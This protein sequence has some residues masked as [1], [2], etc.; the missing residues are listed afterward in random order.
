MIGIYKITSPNNKIYIGQSINVPRRFISYKNTNQ[1]ISHIRLKNSFNKYGVENH[2][3]EIIEICL[4][5]KLNERERYWQDYYDV[6]GIKGLNCRLTTTTDKSGYLSKEVKDK[7]SKSHIGKKLSEETKNKISNFMKTRPISEFQK[8]RSSECNKNKIISNEQKKLLSN[9]RKQEYLNNKLN[10][11]KKGKASPFA[12]KVKCLVSNKEWNTLTECCLENNLS[13]KN[14]SRKLN[15]TRK[16][17]TNYIY[18]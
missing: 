12:K 4:I 6:I 14:M 11:G 2:I 3:F 16:N 10:I 8:Q 17:N 1:N 18:I 7:I 5:D 9:L 15:G 13:I